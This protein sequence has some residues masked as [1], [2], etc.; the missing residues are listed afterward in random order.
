MDDPATSALRAD[1]AFSVQYLWRPVTQ[2]E[3]LQDAPGNSAR[4]ILS[5]RKLNVSR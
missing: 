2:F 4:L 5:R 1:S 3:Q